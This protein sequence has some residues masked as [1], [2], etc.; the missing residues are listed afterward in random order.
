MKDQFEAAEIEFVLA[1]QDC[2]C[3]AV[4][5][6]LAARG[7]RSNAQYDAASAAACGGI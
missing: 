7:K 6:A 3:R 2:G 4:F 5:I 1:C